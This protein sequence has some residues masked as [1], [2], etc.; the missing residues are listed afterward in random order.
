M[1]LKL[2]LELEFDEIAII[3]ECSERLNTNTSATAPKPVSHIFEHRL[4]PSAVGVGAVGQ[5]NKRRMRERARETKQQAI[6]V[7]IVKAN[8]FR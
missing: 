4:S 3:D 6:A 7:Q 8:R 1:Q 2:E 5:A